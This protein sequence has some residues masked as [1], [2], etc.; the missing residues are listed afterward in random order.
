MWEIIGFKPMAAKFLKKV[1]DKSPGI[2]EKIIEAC[3]KE[4]PANPFKYDGLHGILEGLRSYHLI[5]DSIPYR[6]VYEIDKKQ[7]GI[8][9]VGIGPRK[10]IYK[11]LEKRLR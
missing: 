6:I 9:Y 1:K 7:R 3:E 4:I 5:I 10:K 2:F 11:E 8:V